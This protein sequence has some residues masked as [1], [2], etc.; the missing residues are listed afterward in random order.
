MW[1]YSPGS[2]WSGDQ[3]SSTEAYQSEQSGVVRWAVGKGGGGGQQ[4]KM[5]TKDPPF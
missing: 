3:L 2:T 1:S 4:P 5:S